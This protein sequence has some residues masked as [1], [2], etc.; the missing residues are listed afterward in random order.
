[1]TFPEEWPELIA[2]TLILLGGL[3]VVNTVSYTGSIV[4]CLIAGGLLGH[5][6]SLHQAT[7]HSAILL[8]A[9][10]FLVGLM[11]GSKRDVLPDVIV[12]YII[13]FWTLYKLSPRYLQ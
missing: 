8:M 9:L 7:A 6:Y 2:T 13:G 1:L 5:V 11:M 12:M 3:L 10:G 4:V